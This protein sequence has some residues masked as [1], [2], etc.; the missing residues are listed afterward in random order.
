MT[1][2]AAKP[3]LRLRPFGHDCGLVH[4]DGKEVGNRALLDDEGAVH[5]DFAERE[6]R[7]GQDPALGR[8]GQEPRRDRHPGAI[9]AAERRAIGGREAD[10]S[11]T[12][13]AAQETTQQTVHPH[14]LTSY[15]REMLTFPDVAFDAWST[16]RF[17]FVINLC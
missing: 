8:M 5:V 17:P 10:R 6:L 9:S 7:V 13:E 15:P 11:T 2:H 14:H 1:D 16:D 3:P 4:H 12:D